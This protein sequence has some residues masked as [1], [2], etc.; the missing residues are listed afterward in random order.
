[1]RDFPVD[2]TEVPFVSI[3][4]FLQGRNGIQSFGVILFFLWRFAGERKVSRQT[5]SFPKLDPES[6]KQTEGY[7][8]DKES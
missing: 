2:T 5:R 3:V 8:D 1:M 4:F 6:G 7:D